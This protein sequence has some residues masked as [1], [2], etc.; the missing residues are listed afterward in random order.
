MMDKIEENI[1]NLTNNQLLLMLEKHEEYTEEA[2]IIAKE[3]LR[4]RNI[5]DDI[6]RKKDLKQKL[7]KDELINLTKKLCLREG[8]D[9]E[10]D[11]WIELIEQNVD[12]PNVEDLILIND[13][14]LSPEQIVNIAINYKKTKQEFHKK[15]HFLL[16]IFLFWAVY[17]LFMFFK[18]QLYYLVRWEAIKFLAILSA[19]SVI[20]SLLIYNH[21]SKLY[22]KTV[23]VSSYLFSTWIM[24]LNYIIYELGGIE[25]QSRLQIVYTAFI[26]LP[27]IN[28]LINSILLKEDRKVIKYYVKSIFISS[29]IGV[30]YYWIYFLSML[31]E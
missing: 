20:Y 13:K 31:L 3:E 24:Y 2:L 14:E 26:I 29:A 9:N 19:L 5:T 15:M 30:G 23:I 25:F 8:T 7:S 16:S 22:N 6:K 21:F 4:G 17:F 28:I 12:H 1:R 27:F 11:E 18:E 10:I